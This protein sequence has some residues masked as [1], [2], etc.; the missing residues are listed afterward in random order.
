MHSAF[1]AK[2][3]RPVKNPNWN[4]SLNKEWQ[5]F[6][7]T[8]LSVCGFLPPATKLRQGNVFTPVCQ[9]FCSLGVSATPLLVRH[10]LGRHPQAD[11]PWADALLGRYPLHIACWDTVNK[12]AVHIL[13]ECILV[14]YQNT[15]FNCCLFKFMIFNDTLYLCMIWGLNE[16]I[17]IALYSVFCQQERHH[18]TRFTITIFFTTGASVFMGILLRKVPIAVLF[19]VFLY[20]GV[21]SLNG[22]QFW[23]RILLLLTP[24][25]HHPDTGYVRKVESLKSTHKDSFGFFSNASLQIFICQSP[26]IGPVSVATNGIYTLLT[27]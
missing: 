19:G 17:K 8:S 23:D 1:T 27:G 25:K 12:R 9:S 22:I 5:Q 6:L 20:M 10:P 26:Q 15:A 18:Y 4:T 2:R 24:V 21:A 14:L 11:T 16:N 7:F 13:L 3:M